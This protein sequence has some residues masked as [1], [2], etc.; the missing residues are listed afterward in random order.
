MKNNKKQTQKIPL[1]FLLLLLICMP[2]MAQNGVIV[3][4]VVVDDNGDPITGATIT[5][6]GNRTIGT[7]TNIDGDFT[8]TVPNAKS[9]LV[10]SFIGMIPQEVVANSSSRLKITLADNAEQLEEVVVVGYGQQKKASVVGA[11]TQ[12][13]GKVLERA[14]GVS[15]I[16]A[17]LTGNLPGVITTASTGMPGEEQPKIVIR[18]VSSWNN[19]DPLILVDGIERPMNSVDIS[20]VQSISVLKDASATAVYGVKGANGVILITTKRGNEGRAKIDIGVNMTTK[21]ASKLPGKYDAYDAL[22]LRNAAIENELGI[23]PESWNSILPVSEIEK[24][25]SQSTLE[26]YE[27]YPNV[28]WTDALFKNHAMSYNANI[29]V[30][31][32]TKYVRYFAAVDYLHEGDLFREWD[33]KRGYNAGYGYNRV[34]ARSNL[35]FNLTKTTVLRTNISG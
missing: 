1:L 29:N 14:G 7:I 24:Y 9:V 21:M 10:I 15:D 5:V 30:S 16:G 2:I 6:K 23:A 32:G 8:I 33:N 13:S 26:E 18:G 3:K 27:R 12:T 35:D 20:S 4:G 34:N 28:D 11:I 19:S 31:G 22:M 17:A 25:R